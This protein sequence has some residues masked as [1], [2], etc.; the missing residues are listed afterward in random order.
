MPFVL[1]P[2]EVMS[3]AVFCDPETLPFGEGGKYVSWES[4][5]GIQKQSIEADG[6]TER[7]QKIDP[8]CFHMYLPESGNID[9]EKLSRGKYVDCSQL[10]R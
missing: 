5:E 2:K 1:F 8:D 4:F 10:E 9:G 3:A 7:S 6:N